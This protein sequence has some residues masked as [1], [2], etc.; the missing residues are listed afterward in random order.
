MKINSDQ[1]SQI[2]W[3]RILILIPLTFSLLLANGCQNQANTNNNNSSENGVTKITFWHG[4]NPPENRKI[5]KEL[6]TKFNE[7]NPNIEVEE[8]YVGQPD[9]QVPK[10]VSSIVANQTPELLWYAPQLTGKLKKLQAIKPVDEW[11]NNSPIKEEIDQAMFSTMELDGKLWSVPF[12]ANNTA[13]FYRPSLFE[14]VGITELPKT[15]EELQKAAQNLTVDTNEDG[16]IDQHGILLAL[17]KGEFT[18]FVWLPFIFSANG[19]IIQNNQPNLIDNGTEKALELGANLV[20]ENVAVLSAPDRGY[21]LDNFI[22]GKVAMQITGPWTLGQLGQTGIDYGAFPL[23]KIEQSATVLGGEN[24]FLFNTTPEKEK[25]ALQFLEYILG[26]EFQTQWALK[27]G[28]LPINIK[29]QQSQEYQ[30][31]VKENPVVEVFLEQMSSAKSRPIT[32]NYPTISENLGRAIE[33]S[34]L[35]EK[36]PKNALKEAQ[37]RIE[38]S[39]KN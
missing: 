8:L 21:E 14:K 4:I 30:A 19:E 37:K 10:I 27:T 13:M 11:L 17:G 15:W 24:I 9:E 12:A 23:P 1:K 36:T 38:L 25:A 7:S 33:A 32:E 6:L 3:K 34:L 18:V 29:A 39:I 22:A 2:K 28:Y 31:F 5:F 16:V 35:G 26:E 20:K